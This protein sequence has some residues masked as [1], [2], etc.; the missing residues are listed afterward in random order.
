MSKR[1]TYFLGLI[2][3][4][5]FSITGVLA[6]SG[7][8]VTEKLPPQECWVVY[9]ECAAA[10][11]GDEG[12]RSGC[13]ADFTV[14]LAKQ[15]TGQC[16]AEELPAACTQYRAECEEF[17]EGNEEAKAQCVVDLDVCKLAHGC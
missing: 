17:S 13:Y 14:C 3:A 7:D 5:A 16:T 9:S 8:V 12:W 2:F 6:Q 15:D 1:Y 4:S 11:F 10:A